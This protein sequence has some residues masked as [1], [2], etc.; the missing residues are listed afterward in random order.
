M[1]KYIIIAVSAL[2]AMC[3]CTKNEVSVPSHEITFQTVNY[4]GQTKALEGSEF[5][6]TDFG[7]FAWSKASAGK[8]YMDN[9]LVTKQ[10]GEWKAQGT[11][12]WPKDANVDFISY[13]PQEK[14]GSYVTIDETKISY[15]DFNAAEKQVDLLYADKVVGYGYADNADG[16]GVIDGVNTYKTVPAFFRHAL[17]QLTMQA[18]LAYE[19]KTNYLE[20]GKTVK[21]SYRWE[22]EITDAKLTGVNTVGSLDLTL[23]GTENPE[24]AKTYPW[25]KP[26]NELWT[27]G[28]P[29][30]VSLGKGALGTDG[31]KCVLLNAYYVIPQAVSAQTVEL[32][33]NIKT[34]RGV[35]SAEPSLFLNEVGVKRTAKL[36]LPD[37]PAWKINQATTY[38]FVIAPTAGSG[39]DPEDPDK[40]ID[41]DDPNLKDVEI[42]FDPAVKGWDITTVGATIKL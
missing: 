17:A 35:G 15:K 23:S 42:T 36:A 9:E 30:T 2:V 18:K 31:S 22:I 29:A 20:D 12:Y 8:Y 24:L 40:P 26:A 37:L 34:Y 3:A 1:K 5:T 33:F 7:V 28:T 25:I 10:G 11:Y 13:Y 32:T 19:A 39:E 6:Y 38:V 41:P 21:D 14:V 27:S 16:S 4:V